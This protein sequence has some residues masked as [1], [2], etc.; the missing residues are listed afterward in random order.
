MALR[1]N[2]IV[3]RRVLLA[4]QRQKV[5]NISAFAGILDVPRPSVSRILH[6]LYKEG[7][8]NKTAGQWELTEGGERLARTLSECRGAY[9]DQLVRRIARLQR[10]LAQED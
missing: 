5:S 6:K 4:L 2:S 9:R 1:H 10:Q 3:Q 8:A 7:L